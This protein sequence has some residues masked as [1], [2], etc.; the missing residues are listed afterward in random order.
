VAGA[1][2][3]TALEEPKIEGMPETTPTRTPP[4]KSASA[5][6]DPVRRV[7]GIGFWALISRHRP[8]TVVLTLG[9]LLRVVALLGYRPAMW[10]NDSYDYLHAAMRPYPHP[11][12][13]GG[14]S[15]FLMIMQPFH[16]FALVVTVQHAMGVAMAVMIYVLLRQRFGL[17]GWGAALAP[18][19]VL[20]DAYQIQLEHVILSDVPFTFLVFSAVTLLLWRARP[21]WKL[22]AAI[23]LILGIAILTRSVGLPVLFAFIVFMLLRRMRWRVIAATLVLATLPMVG[24]MGWFHSVHGKFA[25]TDSSGIFLYARVYKF[26]DC[27]KINP[28]VEE[29]PLC[30]L[31]RHRLPF[32]QDG[33]WNRRSPL[34]RNE[35]E[36]FTPRQNELAGDFSQ[37]A[38]L[39]QPGDYLQVVAGDFFRV[40]KWNRTVFPDYATYEQ[41][42]FRTT[43]AAV[44]DWRMSSDLTAAQEATQYEQGHARTQIAEP[45]G[46]VMRGYQ[47]YVYLRGTLLGVILLIGLAGLAAL[48]RRLG[49]A[50]LLPWMTAVGLLLAPA[51]TAEFD[52]RY[53]LPTVPLACLAAAMAFSP[54]ARNGFTRFMRRRGRT[55]GSTEMT[56]TEPERTP[57]PVA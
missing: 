26:A 53:I 32:S 55:T 29:M 17:P 31:D 28:P 45:F 40:F 2:E 46:A 20:L 8:F 11:I 21:S 52:Y 4:V 47:D 10:F 33:I 14:Y 18:A 16:S 48:W 49:G 41:Y 54:E 24:Y 56:E 12:R 27:D 13:P 30:V 51:A 15:F 9:V 7:R 1:S 37:R 50:A 6:P 19:P 36:R 3:D 39:A 43:I 23:G 34:L 25:M 38:I 44:P 22:G 35:P 5:G 42:E 57:A